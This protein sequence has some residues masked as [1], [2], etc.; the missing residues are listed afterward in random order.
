MPT[1]TP[2]PRP[3]SSIRGVKAHSRVTVQ[4]LPRLFPDRKMGGGACYDA[5]TDTIIFVGGSDSFPNRIYE[6]DP[7]TW[8]VTILDAVTPV[9]GLAAYGCTP[10]VIYI[11]GALGATGTRNLR[12]RGSPTRRRRSTGST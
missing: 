1:A 10:K 6:I 2:T 11:G 5:T 7:D 3:T 8:H 12:V 4:V 9:H